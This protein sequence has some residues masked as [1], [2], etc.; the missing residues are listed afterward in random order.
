MTN[1]TRS[2]VLAEEIKEMIEGHNM[3]DVLTALTTCIAEVVVVNRAVLDIGTVV[4]AL[5]T[6]TA[7]LLD[8]PRRH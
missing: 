3:V 2:L 1:K 8:A 7:A 4:D 6:T 5:K